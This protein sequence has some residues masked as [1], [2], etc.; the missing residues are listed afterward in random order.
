M[1]GSRWKV[2]LAGGVLLVT[3]GCATSEEWTTWG[4]HPS[5]FASGDHLF[6]SMRN[7]EDKPRVRREDLTKSREQ[8]WW[9][10]TITVAQ[11]Q[12]LER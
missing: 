8:G 10:K 12:I 1:R 5:H 3:S 11:D 7:T 4:E 2:L 9:G 6:F